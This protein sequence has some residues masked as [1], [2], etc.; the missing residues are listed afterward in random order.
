MGSISALQVFAFLYATVTQVVGVSFLVKTR[1]FSHLGWT[2]ATI[3]VLI[4]SFFALSWL[5]ANGAK[6]NIL[7]PVL[8]ATVPLASIMVGVFFYGEPASWL[9]LALL[10]GAC[11]L[12]GMAAAFG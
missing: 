10:V 12:I 8:A 5:L 1:G 2:I 9:K 3:V 6:L 4:S 11:A 7:L